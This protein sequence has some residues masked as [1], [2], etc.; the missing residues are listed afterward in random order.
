MPPMELGQA[1]ATAPEPMSR[2]APEPQPRSVSGTV[3]KK[4]QWKWI[5]PATNMVTASGWVAP[6]TDPYQ[7]PD[8][9]P[10]AVT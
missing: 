8:G 3:P 1:T 5:D 7:K 2:P 9:T 6:K 4:V 10:P